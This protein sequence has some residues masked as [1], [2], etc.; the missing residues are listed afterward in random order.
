MAKSAPCRRFQQALVRHHWQTCGIS[1]L[2]HILSSPVDSQWTASPKHVAWWR[3]CRRYVVT[4]STS[5]SASSSL[6]V[7]WP[8]QFSIT[9]GSYGFII[10]SIDRHYHRQHWN[11]NWWWLFLH[12]RGLW[13]KVRLT[14]HSPTALKKEK[15]KEEMFIGKLAQANPDFPRQQKPES[16]TDTVIWQESKVHPKKIYIYI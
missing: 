4:A 2:F 15:K 10:I 13:G 14:Y 5:S 12:E 6:R 7:I 8:S 16:A 9:I 1:G 3:Q 11:F